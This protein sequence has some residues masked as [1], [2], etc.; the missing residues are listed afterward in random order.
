MGNLLVVLLGLLHDLRPCKGMG[1]TTVVVPR[2]HDARYALLVGH[3][4][5]QIRLA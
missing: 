1:P 2:G 5:P 3:G 4:L